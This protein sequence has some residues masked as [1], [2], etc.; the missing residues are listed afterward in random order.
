M[1]EKITPQFVRLV[2][3]TFSAAFIAHI[4]LQL[5]DEGVKNEICTAVPI[6][7]VPADWLRMFIVNALNQQRW[8]NVDGLSEWMAASRLDG[9]SSLASQVDPSDQPKMKILERLAAALGPAVENLPRLL[10]SV[11]TT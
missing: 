6:P 11:P 5:D 2:Q 7:D 9:F 8:R 1:G 4:E 10:E 3:P